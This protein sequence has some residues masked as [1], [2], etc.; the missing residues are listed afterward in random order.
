MAMTRRAFVTTATLA[1]LG[2]LVG[3]GLGKAEAASAAAAPALRPAASGSSS[4]RCARC[5][6]PGHS[7]LDGICV[8]GAEA[9]R[10]VRASAHALAR[11]PRSGAKTGRAGS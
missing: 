7:T 1:A 10:A 11:R 2:A 4:S 9:R 5:G 6:S 3:R 8:E